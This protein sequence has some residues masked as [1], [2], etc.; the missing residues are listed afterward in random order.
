MIFLSHIAPTIPMIATKT[1]AQPA[2]MMRYGP[3]RNSSDSIAAVMVLSCTSSH[4]PKAI[5]IMPK[6]CGYVHVVTYGWV[7]TCGHI[8]VGMYMWSHM[9]GYVHVVTWVVMGVGMYMWSH[10]HPGELS[11]LNIRLPLCLTGH[12]SSRFMNH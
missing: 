9:G 2:A 10:E 4:A 1:I 7:C 3:A 8:W 5:I 12:K 6:I 11:F